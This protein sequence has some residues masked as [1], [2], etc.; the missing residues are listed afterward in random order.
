LATVLHKIPARQLF[1]FNLAAEFVKS[2]RGC[3]VEF[4]YGS[5]DL[6]LP[7]YD[8]DEQPN[9][10]KRKENPVRPKGAKKN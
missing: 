7:S 2:P 6:V 1:R 9:M 8:D 10:K 4:P 3:E 5:F